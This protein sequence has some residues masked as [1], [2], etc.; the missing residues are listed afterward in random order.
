V[1]ALVAGSKWRRREAAE[2]GR[3]H[4]QVVGVS[5][6]EVEGRNVELA[7]VQPVEFGPVTA[8][9]PL[10]LATEYVCEYVPPADDDEEWATDAA[11]L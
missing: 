3:D 10:D 1:S 2:D 4:L 7:S 9:N 5:T 6:V 8:M 11:D